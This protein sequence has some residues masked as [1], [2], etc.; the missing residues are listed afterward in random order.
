VSK[1]YVI[2]S[3]QLEGI[4]KATGHADTHAA[5]VV[6]SGKCWKIATSW[7]EIADYDYPE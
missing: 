7:L 4:L 3:C 2:C 5:E 6:V 1:T